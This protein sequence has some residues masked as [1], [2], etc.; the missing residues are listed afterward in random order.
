MITPVSMN[1]WPRKEIFDFFS[2][3]SQ[4]F[5]SVTFRQDVTKLYRFA[6]E[7]GIS[8]YYALTYL[9][10]RAVNQVNAFRYLIKDGQLYLSDGRSPSFTDLHPGCEQFHIV[11]MPCE[12]DIVSFSRAAREKSRAQTTF[13]DMTAETDD[14]IYISC[15]PWVELTALTNERDFDKDDSIPRLAWG[16]YVEE[17]GRKTVHMSMELNHRFVDGIHVGKFHEILSEFIEAL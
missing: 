6:K 12:G 16:K 15:L 4:P 13:I 8:F 5:F 1:D 3:M 14:L 10:T 11:T 2:P 17:N 7:N 9:C